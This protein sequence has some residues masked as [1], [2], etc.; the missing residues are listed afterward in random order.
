MVA[1]MVREDLAIAQ[2]DDFCRKEGFKTFDYH[3]QKSN[4]EFLPKVGSLEMMNFFVKPT[5]GE[6]RARSREK[7]LES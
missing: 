7:D 4:F 2:R 3:E 5:F 1:E 6:L